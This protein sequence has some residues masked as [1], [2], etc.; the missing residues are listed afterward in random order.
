MISRTTLPAD[1]GLRESVTPYDI[2]HRFEKIP[3]KVYATDS[4]AVMAVADQI[5]LAINEFG[6]ENA[7][8]DKTFALGLST[9]RTPLG[10]YR[11]LAARCKRGEVSFSRVSVYSLDEF[12]PITAEEQQSRNY[13]IHEDFINLIDIKPEN[14]HLIDAD[15]DKADLEN[16]CALYDKAASNIDLMVIGV[17][18]QGQI[19]FNDTGVNPKSKTRMVQLSHNTRTVL[20]SLFFGDGNTPRM[21]I[22]L[23][24]GTVMKAKRIILMAWGEDKAQAIKD[25]VEGE[26]SNVVPASLL[27]EHSNISMYI[28]ENAASLLTRR[29]TPW[30]VGSCEWTPKFVRKAVVWLCE[31]VGK[32]ILKLSYNDYIQNSLAELLE[33]QGPYDQINIRVFNDLQHTITGW[34]GGKPNADDSTRPVK[35]TPYPKRV[36]IFSPH[37][38]D[39]V[40]S[41]GGTFH[42]LVT[43]GHDVH[44][45]YETSGNVAVYDDVVLQ[46]LDTAKELGLGD[47]YDEIVE[48]IK[49][50]KKGEPEPRPLLDIKGAIRRAEAK[51]ACRSFGLN[52]RTN[53]H[54]LNLPFYET[55]GIKKG[56]LTDADIEIIIDLF[57]KI[58]PDQVYVA[59]DLTD[60]HGT[61][62]LCTE[63]VFEAMARTA[64]EDWNKECTI[65][66]YRGAW[67]EW[68]LGAV[69]MAVPLSPEE[70]IAK[71]HAIYRHLSQ[72]DIVPFPGADKREFWQRAED[73]TQNTARLYDALGMA[74]YQA[75][76]VFVKMPR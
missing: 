40:I 30:L 58:K 33:E 70:I 55:G 6:K 44:V 50:K 19:G 10:L 76:E 21:G 73:R 64:D 47:R 59:G 15:L 23:G 62:R 1:G 68:N 43:Q 53:C 38:D 34:P 12:Y 74:E 31:K 20:S 45:A 48:V 14:V 26:C 71:R 37:P 51:A 29:E 65:W 56:E 54:F 67:Q 9:G 60:P 42:R 16:Y 75:I 22:T 24:V 32:P 41:M 57:H 2:V 4:E 69:D 35:S 52:D 17:G 13:R 61:H 11:E 27:Q 3:T 46:N 66:L 49:N 28:D 39:D 5:V 25:I 63:A 72:K 18:E 7:A 36:I 8:E